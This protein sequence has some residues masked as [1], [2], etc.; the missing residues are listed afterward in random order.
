MDLLGKGKGISWAEIG[1]RTLKLTQ[2]CFHHPRFLV[3]QDSLS[4]L[5]RLLSSVFVNGRTLC[6]LLGEMEESGG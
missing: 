5:N 1:L 2:F 3:H 4:S 6:C